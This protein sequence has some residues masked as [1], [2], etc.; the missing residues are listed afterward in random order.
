M[1]VLF[2][3][4]GRTLALFHQL[5][6]SLAS[7]GETQRSGFYVTDSKNFD[8]YRKHRP[9]IE[10]PDIEI[11]KEWEITSA[12]RK[13]GVDQTL[14]NRMERDLGDPTLWNAI[15]ADRRLMYGP[16]AAREQ[17]YRPRF[18]Y[19]QL[20]SIIQVGV[21][22][23]EKLF[24]RLKPDLVIGFICVTFGEY[25][26]Y[27]VARR[28]GITFLNLRPTRIR[29]FFYAGESVQEPSADLH[30]TYEQFLA[31][32]IPAA[33]RREAETILRAV[34][35]DHAMYEGVVPV[36]DPAGPAKPRGRSVFNVRIPNAFRLI[37]DV[38]NYNF[39]RYR[40]DI[41]YQGRLSPFWFRTVKRPLRLRRV[42]AALARRYLKDPGALSSFEYAFFPLHKEPEVTLLVYGRNF[43]NQIEAVR[44]VARSLPLGMKLVVKEHPS[45]VGYHTLKYYQK[46]LDIPN[47]VLAA[48]HLTSKEI[49][50]HARLVAIIGGSI[51]LE[52]LMRR[53]PVIALGR[54][55]FSCLPATMF[56][57]NHDGDRL[58]QD[59]R[60]LLTTAAHD[61]IALTSYIAAV[62]GS[63]VPVD[64][65]SVL[66]G[67]TGVYR[68]QN[69]EPYEAQIQ[70]LARYVAERANYSAMSRNGKIE[71]HQKADVAW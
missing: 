50:T 16:R 39:G 49:V 19:A 59:I 15:V 4:Q 40:D 8:V 58:A 42:D 1:N 9:G 6:L 41:H 52:A 66:I 22:E 11:L 61:E 34:R 53:V 20:L 46:L 23:V 37:G 71:K 55:P 64:F 62:V 14:L 56:R 28:R 26:A 10:S 47:V 27:L 25:I 60:D 33:L 17:H 31:G 3:T 67:R 65:Y 2:L 18:S 69:S 45:A 54:V 68:P 30:K 44:N 63:S 70:R 32:E 7:A 13:R 24:D 51:G 5:S 36:A 35:D 38:W 12:A 43:L 21:E 57:T 29:N 48:P